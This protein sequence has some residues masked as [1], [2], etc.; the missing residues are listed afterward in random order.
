MEWLTRAIARLVAVALLVLIAPLLLLLSVAAMF[1]IGRP[2]FFRQVRSG[3]HQRPFTLYKFRSMTDARGHDGEL[4]SDEERVTAF[5]RFLRRSRLDELPGLVNI[6]R[7]EMA[8]VG[9]RPLL[10]PTIEGLGEL[11][12]M[13]ARVRPGLT[14]WSQVNGNTLLSLERKV[15][16]DLWYVENRSF[17]LDC[18]IVLATLWVMVGGERESLIA[19]Q[20]EL[21]S[22]RAPRD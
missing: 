20:P 21:V 11:G 19:R 16:L 22:D 4:L 2:I 13:R 8:F 15:A 1:S 5:G 6:A 3:L 14:G 9:P 18:R 12:E 17:W 7:G 10:P